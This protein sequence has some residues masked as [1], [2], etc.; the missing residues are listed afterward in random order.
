MAPWHPEEDESLRLMLLNDTTENKNW[1]QITIDF[2]RINPMKIIRH[3]K[4][5]R[6]RWNNYINPELRKYLF[7]I[8]IFF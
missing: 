6:E 7:L 5:I 3:A 4:Q 2:N 1:T 8:L